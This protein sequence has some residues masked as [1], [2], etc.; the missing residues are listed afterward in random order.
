[1]LGRTERESGTHA[2][3]AATIGD[4]DTAE[5]RDEP[6]DLLNLGSMTATLA[7]VSQIEGLSAVMHIGHPSQPAHDLE[8][9]LLASDARLMISSAVAVT[10]EWAW[11]GR[12]AEVTGNVVVDEAGM[13]DCRY[14]L[15]AMGANPQLVPSRTS[16]SDRI[17]IAGPNGSLLV[18]RS[19]MPAGFSEIPG[20]E[21]LSQG[22]PIWYGLV[23]E[24]TGWAPFTEPV[25]VW[26]AF[27]P[28]ADHRGSLKESL[29]VFE[30]SGIDLVHLRSQQSLAGPHVFF[31]AFSCENS[32]RL[33]ELLAEISERGVSH[34]VLAVL[35][36]QKFRPGPDAIEPRWTV[37]PR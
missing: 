32:E 35:P 13:R 34:R 37:A 25:Q 30:H 36:G 8:R 4:W 16:I 2:R 6:S 33:D 31:T 20:S 26:L 27:G 12:K 24:T 15:R 14:T 5:N 18:E 10:P 28:H 21:R 22:A 11:V 19:L 1:M 23:G 29:G 9:A 7:T 17:E 3:L